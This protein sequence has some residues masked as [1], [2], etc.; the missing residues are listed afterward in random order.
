MLP[1]P[2]AILPADPKE[3]L[4]KLKEITRFQNERDCVLVV[5][6][7]LD[8]LGGEGPYCVSI[9]TGEPGAAKTSLAKV[10]ATLVDPRTNFLLSAPKNKRDV[11]IAASR[12]GLSWSSI[13]CRAWS[14]LYPTPFAP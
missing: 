2:E 12:R 4:L 11:Y 10:I 9:I 1:L 3:G 6:F 8:A 14:R 13:T 7:M 5:A